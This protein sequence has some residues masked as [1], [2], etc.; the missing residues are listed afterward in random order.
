MTYIDNWATHHGINLDW[1]IEQK[2]KYNQGREAMHG[3]K[4]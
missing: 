1:H 4:Y 3:K 2:M